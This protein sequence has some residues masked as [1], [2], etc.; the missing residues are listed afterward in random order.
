MSKTSK[1]NELININNNDN[2]NK[3]NEEIKT[4]QSLRMKQDDKRW[5]LFFSQFVGQKHICEPIEAEKT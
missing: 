4:K 5:F 1:A 3:E 2:K